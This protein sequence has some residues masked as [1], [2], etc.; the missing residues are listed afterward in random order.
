[1]RSR[2]HGLARLGIVQGRDRATLA[3]LL[4]C[5]LVLVV[6]PWEAW[7]AWV[8]LV[9]LGASAAAWLFVRILKDALRPEGT[10]PVPVDPARRRAMLVAGFACATSCIMAAGLVQRHEEGLAVLFALLAATMAAGVG[11]VRYAYAK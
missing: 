1:M 11:L 2:F 4:L 3:T 8:W 5:L 10:E 9:V 7:T 6:T